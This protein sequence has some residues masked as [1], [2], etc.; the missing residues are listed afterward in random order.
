L[1]EEVRSLVFNIS[2]YALFLFGCLLLFD[3][4]IDYWTY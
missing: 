2:F 3:W 1:E 4:L